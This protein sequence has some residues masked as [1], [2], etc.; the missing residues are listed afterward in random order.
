MSRKHKLVA[1]WIS[2]KATVMHG[3]GTDTLASG[4]GTEIIDPLHRKTYTGK[5]RPHLKPNPDWVT[6][7]VAGVIALHNDSKIAIFAHHKTGDDE[8]PTPVLVASVI[9]G[10]LRV[11]VNEISVPKPKDKRKANFSRLR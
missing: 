9:D 4:A 5:V 8:K 10:R 7:T 11:A 1:K 3:T 6:M 2:G